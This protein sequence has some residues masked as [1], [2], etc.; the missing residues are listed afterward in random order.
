MMYPTRIAS[1]FPDWYGS[2]KSVGSG[3]IF[4]PSHMLTDDVP[5]ANVLAMLEVV[6][7]A[8]PATRWF[9]THGME[10]TT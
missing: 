10:T 9:K 1:F 3:F 8:N 6:A 7:A 2:D 4:S 5:V